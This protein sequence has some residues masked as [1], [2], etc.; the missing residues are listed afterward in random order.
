MPPN[1]TNQY[2]IFVLVH[3][4]PQIIPPFWLNQKERGLFDKTLSVWNERP[5]HFCQTP[6]DS[7][8]IEASH[9]WESKCK[10][11]RDEPLDVEYNL[12]LCL[13]CLIILSFD[14]WRGGSLLG[15][16]KG[17]Q[18]HIFTIFRGEKTVWPLT[19]AFL[20]NVHFFLT[21]NMSGHQ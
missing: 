14:V 16:K 19:T 15:E 4:L 5:H 18:S 17:E 8:M 3:D 11:T 9:L 10:L 20:S 2:K 13:K 1:H 12:G 6:F 7:M 21:I